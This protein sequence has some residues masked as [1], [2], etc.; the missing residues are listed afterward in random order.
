MKKE[1]TKSKKAESSVSNSNLTPL[2]TPSTLTP[3]Q[4]SLVNS[5]SIALGVSVVS[6][7]AIKLVS[8]KIKNTIANNAENN[9]FGANRHTTWAKQIKMAFDNNGWPGTDEP[10]LRHVLLAM[11]SKEDFIATQNQYRKLYKGSNL[12]EDMTGELKST[13]Y[14]EMLAILQAKPNKEG[15]QQLDIAHLS[16]SWAIRLYNALSIYYMGFIPGTDENAVRAVFNEIPT[17][18][19]F[20]VTKQAYQNLYGASLEVDLDG[21]LKYTIDWR[22]LVAE[23]PIT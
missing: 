3:R 11:P 20:S 12:I 13:E 4:R 7:L 21:D 8:N 14:N 23:K 6:L 19:A 17:Q 9:S 18:Q 15:H 1:L 10:A 22:A 2:T 5:L 16:K